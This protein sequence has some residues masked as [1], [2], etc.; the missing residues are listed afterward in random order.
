MKVFATA[1]G[2]VKSEWPYIANPISYGSHVR[3]LLP[4]PIKPS[5]D[6]IGPAATQANATIGWLYFNVENKFDWSDWYLRVDELSNIGDYLL[7]DEHYD[8]EI[9]NAGTTIIGNVGTVNNLRGHYVQK[10]LE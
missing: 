9:P 8:K 7:I 5:G 1:A 10:A 3:V 2:A 4:S 6:I